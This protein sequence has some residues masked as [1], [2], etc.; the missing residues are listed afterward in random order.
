MGWKPPKYL[1][2]FDLLP[3]IVSGV[4]G[5]PR[6]FEIPK[7][8]IAEVIIRHPHFEWFEELGLRWYSLPV[9]CNMGLDLGKS[10]YQSCPFNGW[11]VCTEIGS[12]NL[13]D[14]G[15]YNMLPEI[16]TRMG[17]DIKK[18][19]SLWRDR[20]MMELNEAV[21]YSYQ[22][23]KVRMLDHHTASDE[24]VRFCKQ[25]ARAG[26]E[27]SSEWAFIVPP[28]TPSAT[29]VFF[30]NMFKQDYLPDYRKIDHVALGVGSVNFN[31][32]KLAKKEAVCPFTGKSKAKE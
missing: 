24:Y 6:V 4:D 27:V 10:F 20:A 8:F 25:E 30:M 17:L 12:R 7:G 9:V 23:A 3:L 32:V 5:K 18:P 15:R 26:R 22:T 21:L 29:K 1:G 2:R 14:E 11:Y 28:A 13:G 31:E 19:R 16:A